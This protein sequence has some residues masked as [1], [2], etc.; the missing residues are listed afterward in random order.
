MR[1][2]GPDRRVSARREER[3]T[4]R[5]RQRVVRT[6]GDDRARGIRARCRRADRHANRLR[7]HRRRPR[8]A[9][10]GDSVPD[11]AAELLVPAR[12]RRRSADGVDLRHQRAAPPS[13]PRSA[14]VLARDRDRPHTPTPAR[15][16]HREP[17]DGLAPPR[18]AQS[19][20]E[21][22]GEH[23]RP[24]Q[25]HAAVHR[26]DG[27]AH[28]GQ[29]HLRP[30]ARRRRSTVRTRAPAR[31]GVQ[32]CAG[33]FRRPCR[34]RQHA[35]HGPVGV[36]NRAD[37]GR[38]ALVAETVGARPFD[39]ER[40]TASVVADAPDG[41][42]WLVVKG[43]PEGVLE[44]CGGPTADASAA[45]ARLFDAGS[46]VIAVAA[47]PA[48]GLHGTERRSTSTTS[49]SSGSWSS[50]TGPRSS[51]TASLR[52]LAR[53]GVDLKVIT[54]D[55]E[56]VAITVCRELGVEVQGFADGRRGRRHG[57][58]RA[59]AAHQRDD[60]VRARRARD[61]GANRSGATDAR[62]PTSRSSATA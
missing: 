57:R 49:S 21:T 12:A 4:R 43:E 62:A 52:R 37:E 51:A 2:G 53:L 8:R 23:R 39:H 6:D 40:R 10:R 61:E 3:G 22:T 15:D 31:I 50:S 14:A 9:S 41:S 60:R 34:R 55:S 47:R 46:R 20:R 44:R 58:C 19:A 5:A 11:R 38:R 36:G 13:D 56:Q 7:P 35:R 26:Q 30:R 45:L 24:R 48:P 18:S 42:R 28:R 32:R 27:H 16:R 54:G 17:L 33:R 1:R 59:C 29:D 25:H